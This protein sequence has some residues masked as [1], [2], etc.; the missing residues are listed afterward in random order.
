MKLLLLDTE[1]A[2]NIATVWGIYNINVAINQLLETS[3]LMCYAAK[4]YGKKEI[5]FSSEHFMKHEDMIKELHALLSEADA[6]I[7]Y[8][9]NKFDIPIINREFLKY[10]MSP[11]DPYKSIDLLKVMRKKFRFVSNKLDHVCQELNIGKKAEHE[12]HEL[13]L[14]C[15]DNND[16]AWKR[17]E[18]YNKQDIVLL[19][20]LYKKILPWISN[21]PNHNL[22]VD[23][24]DISCCPNCGSTRI[25]R[26]GV[27][28]L[29][30]YT[31]QRYRCLECGTPLRGT[32]SLREVSYTSPK[33]TQA[34]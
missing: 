22:Y 23:D 10:G 24:P 25:I 19:E 6:V 15:M 33:Y 7:H 5:L 8:N 16:D 13:W 11:P 27:E 3:R 32:K 30:T 31:Y 21:H 28:K 18:E 9:G 34:C 12:G 14:K 20:G 29:K 2:P 26:K 17:M 1:V 4:W